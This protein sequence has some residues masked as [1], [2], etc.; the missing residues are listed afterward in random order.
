MRCLAGE[1]A[2]HWVCVKLG[3]QHSLLL[4]DFEPI[5]FLYSFLDQTM[6]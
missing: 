4:L 1:F 3:S 6:T 2:W 5:F